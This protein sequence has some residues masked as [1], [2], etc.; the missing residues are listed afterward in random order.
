MR[1]S[2]PR[3]AAPAQPVR[4]CARGRASSASCWRRGPVPA[5]V[6]SPGCGP[7]R[8]A[9][10]VMSRSSTS[11]SNA[12]PRWRRSGGER[13]PRRGR[14]RR[15]PAA[16][17]PPVVGA[18]RAARHGRCARAPAGLDRRSRHA[19]GQRRRV[20]PRR[21]TDPHRRVGRGAHPVAA[22]RRR[23][24]APHQPGGGCIDPW[25]DVARSRP[26]RRVSTRRRGG[27]PRRR[28]ARSPA[29]RRPLRRLRHASAVPGR[30][31]RRERRP[32][33][34]RSRRC[35]RRHARPLRRVA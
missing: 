10:S 12:S 11:P 29:L 24:P 14:H 32:E 17:R 6:R 34:R 27:P 4:G 25:T 13:P 16:E 18:R 30:Q 1:G 15:P 28:A 5:C 22:G 19:G 26:S 20:V 9:R 2:C 23:R 35:G 8:C 31:P 3:R 33:R 21:L 7:S